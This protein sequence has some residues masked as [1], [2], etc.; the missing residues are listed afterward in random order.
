MP[1]SPTSPP[2]PLTIEVDDLAARA[3]QNLGHSSWHL[4]S[5]TMV[6]TFA[7]ATGDH[8]WI[9]VD[10]V[11]AATGPFGGTIAHGYLTLSLAPVLLDEVVSVHGAVLV[12]NYGTDRV[13]FPAPVPVG[14]SVRAVVELVGAEEVSGGVQAHF[15][16]S[17]E[18]E[19]VAKPA[20]VAE[21]VFRYYRPR[22]Q[23]GGR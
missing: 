12:V 23:D 1:Q 13:R 16:V 21:I 8:Q 10:P 22:N 7:D 14:S 11:L 9:H 4:I 5:Q 20:C 19:G 6:D 18:L 15:K 17:I 3:G 2:A